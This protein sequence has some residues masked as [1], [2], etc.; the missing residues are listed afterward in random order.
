M[1]N[2]RCRGRWP[3]VASFRDLPAEQT[4]DQLDR[5]PRGPAALVQKDRLL[6]DDGEAP[7]RDACR[8]EAGRGCDHRGLS[9][10]RRSQDDLS[11]GLESAEAIHPDRAAAALTLKVW[12]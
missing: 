7:R 10:R 5:C 2:S 3:G 4:A 1:A 12:S 8:L 11:E 6:A 9:L